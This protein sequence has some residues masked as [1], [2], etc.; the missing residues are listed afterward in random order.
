MDTKVKS[1]ETVTNEAFWKA[2]RKERLT[3]TEMQALVDAGVYRYVLRG[4][5]SVG[6]NAA[7]MPAYDNDNGGFAVAA[8]SAYDAEMLDAAYVCALTG[9]SLTTERAQMLVDAGVYQYR[10]EGKLVPME[11][12]AVLPV[13]EWTWSIGSYVTRR[14]SK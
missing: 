13:Y 9:T 8:R 1:G 6:C 2:L 3:T 7:G 11:Q 5:V 10:K 14:A 12:K 4:A